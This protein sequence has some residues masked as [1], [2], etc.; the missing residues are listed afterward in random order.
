MWNRNSG[1]EKYIDEIKM[2]LESINSR[3][4]QAEQFINIKKLFEN[5]HS[6]EKKVI[7]KYAVRGE[8]TI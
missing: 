7:W 3:I 8:N 1:A 6:E 5:M 2:Q 4:D